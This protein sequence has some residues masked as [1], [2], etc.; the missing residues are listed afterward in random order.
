MSINLA[1]GSTINLQKNDPKLQKVFIGLGWEYL[2]EGIDL[3]ASLFMLGANGKLIH[4]NYFIFYNN[5]TSPD[6][7]VMHQGDNRTGLGNDDDELIL[8][9]LRQ[10][11]TKVMEIHIYVSIHDA[12][13][14][15]HTFGRLKDAYIR[16]VN[17]ENSVEV[18]KY[19]LDANQGFATEVLFGKLKRV[20]DTEWEFQAVGQGS[21][22][23]LQSI[24]NKY[25]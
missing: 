6:G 2:M 8:A 16:I 20:N 24:V 13:Q 10:V 23:G 18:L 17:V 5:L 12:V 15:G 14:R 4:D 22:N 11:D 9:S 7:S 3:D 19:D 21:T 25:V 1:K